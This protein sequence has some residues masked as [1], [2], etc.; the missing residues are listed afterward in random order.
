MQPK[1]FLTNPDR[2]R[3]PRLARFGATIAAMALSLTG[4]IVLPSDLALAGTADPAPT[5]TIADGRVRGV[6]H[7]GGY[8]FRG[9]PYAAP[10]TGD[11]RW[12]P[13]QPPATWKGVR[14]ATQFAPSPIQP[15]PTPF[16]PAGPQSED[17]LYLNVSTPRLSGGPGSG[18]PVLVWF[19]G[20]GMTLGG[21]RYYDPTK[22]AADGVVVVTVNYRLGVFGFLSHPALATKPGGPSGNYG[23]MDQQAAL[24]WVRDNIRQFGGDPARVTIAGQSSG[25]L[26]VLEHLVST[27]SRGLFSR[28]IVQSGAFAM[29]QQSLAQAEAA[30]VA[31]ADSLDGDDQS[32]AFLRHAPAAELVSK[33]P[34]FAIPGVVDGKVLTESVGSALAHGRFARVPILNGSNHDEEATFLA[35]QLAVSGGS[36]VQVG[37]VTPE[38]F[39]E[40]IVSTLGVSEARAAAIAAEYPVDAYASATAALSTL[41]GDANFASTAYQLDKWAGARVPTYAYEFNDDAAPTRFPPVLEPKVATHGSELAYLFDLPDALVQEPFSPEQDKL[42]DTMRVAWAN[43]AAS[44]NPS[45]AALRWPAFTNG[46]AVMSLETPQPRIDTGFAAR[47]HVAFWS[48]D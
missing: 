16:T 11:L 18:R 22:L 31:F 39:Q 36:F 35:S 38:N 14:D 44:G 10:P 12:K 4:A 23:L 42:A 7:P 45:S 46:H 26:N 15:A 21:G 43:F 1:L 17:S 8:A 3:R 30:G 27:G 41:V 32:A 37:Q 29:T 20:G 28:A 25:G 19:H 47:H 9:L 24:R 40:K 2:A 13:P 34:F 5:V 48:A 33:F 6:A